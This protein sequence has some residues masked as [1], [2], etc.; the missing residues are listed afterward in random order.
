MKFGPFILQRFIDRGGMGAVWK[1]IHKAENVPVAVKFVVS[2]RI[3]EEQRTMLLREVRAQ[4]RLQHSGIVRVLDF[5]ELEEDLSD[6]LSQGTPYM[7]MPFIEGGTLEDRIGSMQ[8]PEIRQMLLALLDTLAFGHARG[9]VHRDIKPANVLVAYED[10]GEVYKLADFGIAYVAE[11]RDE[12][13]PELVDSLMVGTPAYMSPEQLRGQWRLFGP[14]TDLYAV[15]AVTWELVTGQPIFDRGSPIA[16]AMA[17]ANEELPG[18]EPVIDVPEGLQSWLARMLEKRPS[19]R[20][21]QAADAAWALVQTELSFKAR[22]RKI[23]PPMQTSWKSPRPP[24]YSLGLIG[25]G[26]SLFDLR[27]IPM[28][29]REKERNLLW[30]NLSRTHG[31]GTARAIVIE[32]PTGTGKTRLAQWLGRRADEVGAAWHLRALHAVE[33]TSGAGLANMME[34]FFRTWGLSRRETWETIFDR[35]EELNEDP[36]RNGQDARALTEVIHGPRADSEDDAMW[37]FQNPDEK[38]RLLA[39]VMRRIA[40]GR[41]LI[42]EVDD[43]QWGLE[44][45]AFARYVMVQEPD[46]P[47][48][49]VVTSRTDLDLGQMARQI[50]GDDERST[51]VELSALSAIEH[52]LLIREMLPLTPDLLDEVARKTEG[53]PLFARQLLGEWAQT[54]ELTSTSA[55]FRLLGENVAI[56]EVI[57]DLWLTRLERLLADLP[58]E[59]EWD[60]LRAVE[61]AAALGREVDSAEWLAVCDSLNLAPTP[62]LGEALIRRGLATS[63]HSGWR[64][65]HSMLVA[66]VIE[67][68][69][70][71]GRWREANMAC[72][73]VLRNDY[74]GEVSS[75]ATRLVTHLRRAERH[76]QALDYAEVAW[77]RSRDRGANDECSRIL[78][79]WE[80]LAELAGISKRDS[81]YASMRLA[82]AQTV[83]GDQG[84][85]ARAIEMIEKIQSELHEGTDAQ[86][87]AEAHQL[88]GH[89]LALM[90]RFDEGLEELEKARQ[91]LRSSTAMVDLQRL[92]KLLDINGW[93]L[94]R[95]GRYDEAVER[96][97]EV[98]R[99]DNEESRTS[100][101]LSAELGLARIHLARRDY[102]R[103]RALGEAIAREAARTGRLGWQVD[104]MSIVAESHKFSRNWE[105][106]IEAAR[107]VFKSAQI[108]RAGYTA[109]AARL[110]LAMSQVGAAHFEDAMKVF[111]Q[112]LEELSEDGLHEF[113]P[114]MLVGRAAC[115]AASSDWVA[116]E[117]A[118]DRLSEV[119]K[120]ADPEFEWFVDVACRQIERFSDEIR[121]NA[122]RAAAGESEE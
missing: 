114:L 94:A 45:L 85:P 5:G 15:G 118:I 17:H 112:S 4:A 28:I 32:G 110:N 9:L 87:T 12:E 6:E 107:A 101:G 35:L 14:S 89:Y 50:L 90:R 74:V 62:G 42:V 30:E 33:D 105:Q 95:L 69:V 73:R 78:N 113:I 122:L 38:F 98:L 72:A 83:F 77:R 49:F 111:G 106:A 67:N 120:P 59:A 34:T 3:D 25:A 65:V 115:G 100:A 53:N 96:Y 19:D 58:R 43:V 26:L 11:R 63:R 48:V 16:T 99:L 8:W 10:R 46:T 41:P 109:R 44:T 119:E 13:T 93:I 29:G 108:H 64:F 51:V 102:E 81:R 79:Q 20:F 36:S 54:G 82:R 60:N 52:R 71:T 56:P 40:A 117:S 92:A 31:D 104:A 22:S 86:V 39:R 57:H 21:R 23:F 2:Q 55:G 27:E 7:V 121:R 88:K 84:A 97:E 76:E 68:C 18:L 24:E 91:A 70:G 61:A 116:F 66:S 75:V 1:G 103:A 37:H 80:E 47:V